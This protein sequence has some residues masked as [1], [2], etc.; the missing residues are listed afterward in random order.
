MAVTAIDLC[1]RALSL[2]GTPPIQAFTEDSD[3]A[4]LCANL[5]T[6]LVENLMSLH[7]WRFCRKKRQLARLV[8]APVSEWTYAFQLPSDRMG[9]PDTVFASEAVGAAEQT[10][11]EIIGAHLLTEEEEI[12]VDYAY[13]ADEDVFPPYFQALVVAA[14]AADLAFPLTDQQNTADHWE[15][16]AFGT[17]G[18]GGR[19]AQARRADSRS[20]PPAHILGDGGP[21][22]RARRGE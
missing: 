4:Q 22:L 12:W 13:R 20:A 14:L 15:R 2:L 9:N 1:A 17:D 3:A 10:S 11:F 6:G 7:P 8:D 16:K 18:T 5:Y 21:L 19:F